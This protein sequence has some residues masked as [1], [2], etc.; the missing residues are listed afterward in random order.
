LILNQDRLF[1]SKIKIGSA[2]SLICI[3]PVETIESGD[4]AAAIKLRALGLSNNG[5]KT[6]EPNAFAGLKNLKVLDLSSNNIER[7]PD[8]GLNG[9]PGLR[10]LGISS[11]PIVNPKISLQ[12]HVPRA[13]ITTLPITKANLKKWAVA[14]GAGIAVLIAAVAGVIAVSKKE[15]PRPVIGEPKDFK[16]GDKSPML[17]TISLEEEPTIHGVDLYGAADM[18]VELV[19]HLLGQGADINK[20]YTVYEETPLMAAAKAG[21]IETVRLLIGRGADVSLVD[22]QGRTALDLTPPEYPVV[23]GILKYQMNVEKASPLI[24]DIL[25]QQPEDETEGAVVEQESQGESTGPEDFY[26]KLIAEREKERKEAGLG[27]KEKGE[28][29][30]AAQSGIPLPY[31]TTLD[32][33]VASGSLPTLR[34]LLAEGANIDERFGDQKQTSLMMAAEK[35]DV[36]MVKLLVREGANVTL[37]NANEK[38]AA[39]LA[40]EKKRI[41]IDPTKYTEIT[42]FLEQKGSL[43]GRK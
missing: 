17:K 14:L 19:E 36:G 39:D 40:W 23:R 28:A 26:A 7:I 5:L 6:I 25:G 42:L 13:F 27:E 4:L 34:K 30:F 33:A 11:N 20:K 18:R 2:Y 31:V 43:K 35:G 32:D 16:K 21:N 37:K 8:G 29:M 15:Q 12:A 38:T 10:F 41:S 22:V 1:V 24:E 9:M 3:G